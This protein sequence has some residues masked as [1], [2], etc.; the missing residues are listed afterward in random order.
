MV[1]GWICTCP[2]PCSRFR[3]HIFFLARC[4]EFCCC[5]YTFWLIHCRAVHTLQP[6]CSRPST[7]SLG[8]PHALP[9]STL[10]ETLNPETYANLLPCC[11]PMRSVTREGGGIRESGFSPNAV[12]NELADLPSTTFFRMDG[13]MSGSIRAF[14]GFAG[15]ETGGGTEG[16]ETAGFMTSS[17]EFGEIKES[18]IALGSNS[19]GFQG[20]AA[21]TAATVAA[22]A[23]KQSDRTFLAAWFADRAREFDS[24]GGQLKHALLMCELGVARV[25]PGNGIVSSGGSNRMPGIPG[26]GLALAEGEQ[27]LG[28]AGEQSA[29]VHKILALRGVLRHLTSL[30]YAG[31]V[32]PSISLR[33]W[34]DMGWEERLALILDNSSAETI[35]A[36]VRAFQETTSIEARGGDNARSV[37]QTSPPVVC[38]PSPPF[39]ETLVRVLARIIDGRPSAETMEACAAVAKASRPEVPEKDRLLRSPEALL[40]LL[41]RSCYAWTEM[42]PDR[43][44]MFVFLPWGYGDVGVQSARFLGLH[45]TMTRQSGTCFVLL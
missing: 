21:A 25:I 15:R 2:L 32:A 10:P 42:A 31:S 8:I 12:D 26:G 28:G 33:Q 23:L 45:R 44:G 39:E 30:V 41:L 27:E 7:I 20:P 19:G 16:E 5:K 22:A 36:D 29:S 6:L 3:K 13:V 1:P 38:V 40:T 43:R 14:G 18:G 34:E 4:F 17:S 35:E 24:R 37:H 9:P 11:G